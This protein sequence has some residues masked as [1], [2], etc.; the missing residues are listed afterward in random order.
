[1]LVLGAKGAFT[2]HVKSAELAFDLED[3]TPPRA[4]SRL[5]VRLRL[6]IRGFGTDDADGAPG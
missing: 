3:L 5:F 4:R 1:M 2:F 6:T